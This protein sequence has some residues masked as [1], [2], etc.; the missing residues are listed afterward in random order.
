MEKGIG[1]DP[2][3]S[4]SEV[5]MPCIRDGSIRTQCLSSRTKTDVGHLETCWLLPLTTRTSVHNLIKTSTQLAMDVYN[6]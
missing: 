4:R 3:C 6:I 2:D 5:L 1:L